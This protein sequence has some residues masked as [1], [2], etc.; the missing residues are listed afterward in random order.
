MWALPPA[1]PVTPYRF[2]FGVSQ[3][4]ELKHHFLIKKVHVNVKNLLPNS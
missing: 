4:E 2:F 3:P 1:L